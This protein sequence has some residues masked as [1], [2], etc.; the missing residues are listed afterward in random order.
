MSATTTVTK[1]FQ[2]A[3]AIAGMSLMDFDDI[4]N[5][6]PLFKAAADIFDET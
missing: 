5:E 2:A 4:T 1:P 6:A 3:L